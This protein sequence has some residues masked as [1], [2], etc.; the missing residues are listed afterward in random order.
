MPEDIDKKPAS[1][2]P[3]DPAK[4]NAD[5]ARKLENQDTTLSLPK[6]DDIASTGDA[7]DALLKEKQD[8][9]K[10]DTDGGDDDAAPA[11]E[12]KK[13]DDGKPP[14]D[15]AAAATPPVSAAPPVDAT[16][17]EDP[18]KKKADELFKDAPSLP[19]NASPKSTEAFSAVKIKA[20]QEVS[21]RDKQIEDLG[22]KVADL[23]AKL[24]NPVPDATVKELEELRQFRNK[25]DVEADPKFK[26]FD[27]HVATSHEFIYAE[28]RKSPI[29]TDATIEAIKKYGGP[30]FVDIEE[31][32]KKINDPTIR[33]NVEQEITSIEKIKFSKREA[34]KSAKTNIDHYV[35]ERQKE[36]EN[37]ENRH[38][39]ETKVKLDEYT[40]K[41]EWLKPRELA[42]GADENTK[43][44][45]ASHNAF[46]E[47]IKTKLGTALHDN[48][49]E[50]RAIMLTATAQLLYLQN[51]YEP[52]KAAYESQSKELTELKAK[53]D[54]IKAAS[55]SRL[56]N[57]AAPATATPPAKP[58]DLLNVRSGDALDALRD[59]M[60]QDRT[61]TQ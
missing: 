18:H 50:M 55:L 28:L 26:E 46:V 36:W 3:P 32:F 51:L 59:K 2:L 54:K 9:K 11:V 53:M 41:I 19:A 29:V 49:P 48:S 37:S 14:G 40:S 52:L 25:L 13:D 12:P 22:K 34:I 57:G 31:L 24:K 27:R 44:A 1:Q 58:A 7:L 47:D 21:A 35:A 45:V 30:E 60:I 6:A 23:E 56:P 15:A 16:P 43:K 38:V 4:N 61:K 39:E 5:V 42:P 10:A 8:K 17:P 33:R 20:A